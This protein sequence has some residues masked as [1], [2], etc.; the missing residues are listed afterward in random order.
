[1]DSDIIIV[2][3]RLG[4]IMEELIS[5]Y[6]VARRG[7]PTATFQTD[8]IRSLCL[9]LSSWVDTLQVMEIAVL[10]SCRDVGE[11]D[12]WSHC[13]GEN[14]FSTQIFHSFYQDIPLTA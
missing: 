9:S 1:M 3:L 5:L 14:V 13:L 4:G 7:I 2:K 12:E 10:L 6:S 8:N 11:E